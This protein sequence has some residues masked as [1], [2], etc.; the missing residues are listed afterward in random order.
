MKQTNSRLKDLR[1]QSHKSQAQVADL[2][3]V[4]QGAY[5]QLERGNSALSLAQAILL[6]KK[7]SV[8]I[9]WL[10]TG[11][12]RKT[13]VNGNDGYI[14]LIDT[15]AY[16]GYVHKRKET[17]EALEYYRIP[18][19]KNG[20]YA[21]FEVEGNSMRPTILPNDHIICSRL[22]NADR[23]ID[24]S[25]CVIV[26]TEEILVKRVYKDEEYPKKVLLKSD[27]SSFPD[28]TVPLKDINELW[29]VNAKLSTTFFPVNNDQ[30]GRIQSLEAKLAKLEQKLDKL[31]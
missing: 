24:G 20:E 18:G 9:D 8:T 14:P 10:A 19:F 16:A 27:N 29:L 4:S 5:S 3:G 15:R 17:M 22:E 28:A 31:I 13:K 2:L 21:I 6:S 1:I 12:G 25:L 23:F 26:T 7:Y 30:D 11:E